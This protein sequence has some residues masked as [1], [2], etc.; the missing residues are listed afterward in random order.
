MA[1][2]A[3]MMLS[4]PWTGTPGLPADFQA[5][6]RIA[7]REPLV[8]KSALSGRNI[9]GLAVQIKIG[10][11][12]DGFGQLVAAA[13]AEAEEEVVAHGLLLW[14]RGGVRPVVETEAVNVGILGALARLSRTSFVR[15]RRG[16][17]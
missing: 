12:H 11:R 1:L 4:S 10:H 2:C 5:R 3:R 9:C 17:C 16:F 15:F 13:G 7:Q 14:L 6:L 8:V